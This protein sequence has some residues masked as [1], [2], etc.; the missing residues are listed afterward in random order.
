[1]TPDATALFLAAALR[2]VDNGH[3]ST[4]ITADQLAELATCY[5][6]KAARL[7]DAERRLDELSAAYR[8]AQLRLDDCRDAQRRLAEIA[9]LVPD[10]LLDWAC[11]YRDKERKAWA[12]VERLA[13]SD[14]SHT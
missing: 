12:E 7:E 8:G 13:S 4:H 2:Q 11:N 14:N 9:A 5:R 3:C 6:C 1:M 10:A